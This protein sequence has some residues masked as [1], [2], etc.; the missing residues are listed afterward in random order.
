MSVKELIFDTIT[1][2]ELSIPL[3]YGLSDGVNFPKLVYFHVNT[4]EKRASNRKYKKHHIYQLNLFDK[5]PHDL[6]NSEILEKIQTAIE[7]TTLNTGTWQEVIEVD[8]ETKETQFM[9]YMEVYS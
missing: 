3:S 7:N 9:Y 5:K 8:E 4:L 2:L 6:D 1:D